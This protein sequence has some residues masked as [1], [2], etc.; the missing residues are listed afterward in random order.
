MLCQK[1]KKD[2]A[3]LE[4]PVPCRGTKCPVPRAGQKGRARRY[5]KELK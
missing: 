1:V 5:G 3:F 4:V 2:R